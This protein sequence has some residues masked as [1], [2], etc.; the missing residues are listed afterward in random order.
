MIDR[1]LQSRNRFLVKYLLF[2]GETQYQPNRFRHRPVQCCQVPWFYRS[3]Q[4]FA[5]IDVS[6]LIRK[7]ERQYVP[8]IH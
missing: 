2:L 6:L 1:Y 8:F 3:E 7:R 4:Q 5:L